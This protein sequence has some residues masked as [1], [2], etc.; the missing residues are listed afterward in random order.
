MHPTKNSLTLLVGLLFL[1][2]CVRVEDNR[3]P[4]LRPSRLVVTRDIQGVR[5]TLSTEKNTEYRI[6]FREENQPWT[7]LPE[8]KLIRGNGQP[9]EITD[10]SPSAGRRRYRS[11]TL[12]AP[13]S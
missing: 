6:Y 3:Q 4:S 10:P 11:E 12:A 13:S 1:S 9:V 2:A 5:L 8:G 7:L